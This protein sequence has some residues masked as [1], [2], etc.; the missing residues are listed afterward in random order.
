MRFHVDVSACCVRFNVSRKSLRFYTH[1]SNR[2]YRLCCLLSVK[3]Y[4]RTHR[5]T[6]TNPYNH[7]RA[8]VVC[9]SNSR[10]HHS[11]NNQIYILRCFM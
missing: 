2:L 6:V 1:H 5:A 7:M 10:C 9:S 3:H 8:E 11:L 4:T